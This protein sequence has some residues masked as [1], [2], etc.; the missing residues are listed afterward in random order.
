MENPILK[1][2]NNG[3]LASDSVLALVGEA[4]VDAVYTN[5][6][7]FTRDLGIK[8]G[9]VTEWRDGQETHQG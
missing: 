8:L 1:Y 7:W 5:H 3:Y 2:F 4:W 6:G 9:A